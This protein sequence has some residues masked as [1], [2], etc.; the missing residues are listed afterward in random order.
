VTVTPDLR[1]A[2]VFYTALGDD[3]AR[4]ST[5]AGLRSATTHLRQV[6][7]QQVRMKLLPELDFEEDHTNEEA[8]RIEALIRRLHEEEEA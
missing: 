8:D 2:T 5:A 6:L 7:G 1:R 4:S 3:R